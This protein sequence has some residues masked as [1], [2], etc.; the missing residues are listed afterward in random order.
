MDITSRTNEFPAPCFPVTC[1]S[2]LVSNSPTSPQNTQ[3]VCSAFA[4]NIIYP[5][6]LSAHVFQIHTHNERAGCAEVLRSRSETGRVRGLLRSQLLCGGDRFIALYKEV[7]LQ[8]TFH[9]KS[10]ECQGHFIQLELLALLNQVQQSFPLPYCCL[11]P[12][13]ECYRQLGCPQVATLL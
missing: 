1:L 10:T 11:H 2:I 4:G 8:V 6:Y 7:P 13:I 5:E 3:T 12:R 9:F